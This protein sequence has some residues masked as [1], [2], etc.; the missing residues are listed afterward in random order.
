MRIRTPTAVGFG[1]IVGL[2]GAY[3]LTARTA[4]TQDERQILVDGHG[5]AISSFLR[6]ES[7]SA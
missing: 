5:R 3:T 2:L 1:L 7:R 6:Q 4:P